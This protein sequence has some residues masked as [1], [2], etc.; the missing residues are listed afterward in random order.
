MTKA[1]LLKEI[2]KVSHDRDLL[3]AKQTHWSSWKDT[4][5]QFRE[6]AK[7]AVSLSKYLETLNKYMGKIK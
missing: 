3:I 5:K 1:E 4:P 6:R 7:Q 2:C